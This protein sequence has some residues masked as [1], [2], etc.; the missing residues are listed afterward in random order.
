MPVTLALTRSIKPKGGD[1]EVT[2]SSPLFPECL[3][4]FDVKVF[5]G[6]CVARGEGSRFR[7]KAHA[8]IEG[9]LYLSPSQRRYLGWI[10]FLSEKR[11]KSRELCLHEAAH[12]LSN[13]GHTDKWRKKVLE[14]GGTLDAVPGVLKDYHKKKRVPEDPDIKITERRQ[15]SP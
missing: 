4:P 14:I 5:V 13:S 8:H 2:K 7:A 9:A 6:G 12:I 15:W 1:M 3:K 10:C 11:L